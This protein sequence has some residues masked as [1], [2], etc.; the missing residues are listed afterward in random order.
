VDLRHQEEEA[1]TNI[2][3]IGVDLS[4]FYMSVEWDIL[5][6]PAIRNVKYYTCCDEPYLDITFNITMRRKTLFYTV[7][8]IIPCMGISFL[9]VLV[10]YLPS[11]SGEKVSLSIS[12]LLSLT[13]FFLLLAEIIPP[14]S[15]VV[16][17]LGKFVLFT[18]ILDTFSI[19][20]TVV[21]LNVHFRSPQTHTMAPWVRRVFIHIL[22]RLLVMRRPGQKEKNTH[23]YTAAAAVVRASA[24]ESHQLNHYDDYGADQP[25]LGSGP[26]TSVLGPAGVLAAG[27]AS[28][29]M[30]HVTDNDVDVYY[31]KLPSVPPPPAAPVNGGSKHLVNPETERSGSASASQRWMV[32]QHPP[33]NGGWSRQQVDPEARQRP[34]CPI[35]SMG[36]TQPRLP[37]AIMP[38]VAREA[39]VPAAPMRTS[40]YSRARV[41]F[42]VATPTEAIRPALSARRS[43]GHSMV[44]DILPN[45]QCERKNP[46]R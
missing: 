2:V 25:M 37:A 31:K 22:P 15:L 1:G 20:V 46:L 33:V 13:V 28:T 42:T 30:V 26:H 8:L 34:P 18:M 39:A 43:I 27:S 45:V 9:T 3:N 41:S 7:N 29:K 16:P 23:R 40:R 4:E 14:T 19:C 32:N 11:D 36:I 24:K 35:T 21:V 12:I 10:F 17:L 38:P 5:A 44:S 6:V